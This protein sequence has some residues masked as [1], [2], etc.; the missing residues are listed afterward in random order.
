N[1]RVEYVAA[2]ERRETIP[3][4]RLTDATGEVTVF[5]TA[6]AGQAPPPGELRTMDCVDCHNRPS[7][8]FAPSAGRAVDDALASGILP[9][10]LPWIR[11]EAV[12]L[13]EEPYPDRATAEQRIAEALRAFYAGQAT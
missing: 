4:V 7:H 9:Q 1:H 13:L 5:S 12:A 2:D 6:D 11:R 10:D 8:R 3:W